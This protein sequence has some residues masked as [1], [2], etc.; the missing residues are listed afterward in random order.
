MVLVAS[1]P[2]FGVDHARGHEPDPSKLDVF[3]GLPVPLRR[4]LYIFSSARVLLQSGFG[5]PKKQE[6]A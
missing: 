1:E 4:R 6:T 5:E 3:H 2:G